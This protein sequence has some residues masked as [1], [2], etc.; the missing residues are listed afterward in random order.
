MSILIILKKENGS[1]TIYCSR[2]N[3]IIVPK[4]AGESYRGGDGDDIYIISNA[5]VDAGE[6]VIISDTSGLNEIQLI[7]GLEVES[8]LIDSDAV[9]LTLSNGAVI[10]ILGAGSFNFNVGGNVFTDEAGTDKTFSAFVEEDLGSTVPAE[11]GDFNEGGTVVIGQGGGGETEYTVI[12]ADQG[13]LTDMA[14]LD[15]ASDSFQFTDDASVQNFV[16]IAN[17]STDD[18]IEV[19]GATEEQYE[20]FNDG[21]DVNITFNNAGTINHIILTGVVSTNDLVYDEQTFE[22]AIGFDAFTVA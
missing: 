4:L 15:A 12:S 5:T 3:D 6:P 10:Q 17:F 22:A 16:E 14:S 1:M 13:T 11:A 18:Q 2:K 7:D 21:A 9:Q 19:N 20:F 8:S